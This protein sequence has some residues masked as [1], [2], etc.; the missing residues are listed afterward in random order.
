[1][2]NLTGTALFMAGSIAFWQCRRENKGTE[3][4]GCVM[5]IHFGGG[6]HFDLRCLTVVEKASQI[7]VNRKK[8]Y[9]QRLACTSITGNMHSTPTV[10]LWK[11]Y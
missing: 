9:L 3:T 8:A 4:I 7:S 10:Q 5:D 11:T 1:M 2:K 6:T